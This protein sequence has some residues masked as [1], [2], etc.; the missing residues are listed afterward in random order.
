ME[1]NLCELTH[2]SNLFI[3]SGNWLK[4]FHVILNFLNKLRKLIESMKNGLLNLWRIAL[5]YPLIIPGNFGS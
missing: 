5:R 1:E 2:G 3:Q 4:L